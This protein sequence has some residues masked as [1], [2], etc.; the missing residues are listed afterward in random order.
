MSWMARSICRTVF[1]RPEIWI[2]VTPLIVFVLRSKSD[3]TMMLLD[4][5]NGLHPTFLSCYDSRRAREHFSDV[6]R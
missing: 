1:D 5:Y 4:L 6:A 3:M 2:L